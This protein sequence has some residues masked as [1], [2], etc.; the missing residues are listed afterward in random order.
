MH[1]STYLHGGN[2]SDLPFIQEPETTEDKI[3]V[4]AAK[5]FADQGFLGTT[6]KEIAKEAGVNEVTIFRLFKTKNNLFETIVN[7]YSGLPSMIKLMENNFTGDLEEDLLNLSKT[8][9]TIFMK[10]ANIVQMM[11]CEASRVDAFKNIMAKIPEQLIT[12]LANV[13]EKHIAN[14]DIK[15][16]NPYLLGQTFLGFY[17]Y[18]GTTK[19]ILKNSVVHT[20]PE[21]EIIRQFVQI[22][23]DGIRQENQK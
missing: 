20:M 2:M 15:P 11:L 14:G 12:T 16:L 23:L 10:R 1:V 4:A 18:L 8:F 13:F 7:R 3:M 19:D 9:H 6:T 17:F 5:K 21:D 22:F